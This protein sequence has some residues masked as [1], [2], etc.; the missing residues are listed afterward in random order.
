[1]ECG[2]TLQGMWIIVSPPLHTTL[3]N[4]RELPSTPL[5]L[6]VYLNVLIFFCHFPKTKSSLFGS[7]TKCAL[8]FVRMLR[9]V[10]DLLSSV[11]ISPISNYISVFSLSLS[12][13]DVVDELPATNPPH[14][15]TFSTPSLL[16][17]STP[18]HPVQ[19]FLPSNFHHL[20]HISSCCCCFRYRCRCFTFFRRRFSLYLS[21]P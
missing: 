17:L 3:L 8:A 4:L 6:S 13:D 1:M 20:L 21:L 11:D 9:N 18:P 5:R 2:A 15:H 7:C 14:T 19:S 12:N 10:N 16:Q